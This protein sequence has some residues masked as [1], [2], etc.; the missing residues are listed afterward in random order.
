LNSEQGDE[1]WL[2]TFIPLKE[3]IANY[4]PQADATD[5]SSTAD[6]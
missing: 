2:S 1:V 6:G 5:N 4:P 3:M